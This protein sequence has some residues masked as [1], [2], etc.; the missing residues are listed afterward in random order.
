MV[1]YI[2]YERKGTNN[3]TLAQSINVDNQ[4]FSKYGHS[5]D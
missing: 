5:L 3:Q 4:N 2:H 1:S